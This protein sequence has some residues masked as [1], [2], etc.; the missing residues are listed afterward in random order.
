[1]LYDIRL[2]ISYSYQN[3][4]AANR[5]M[6]R[7]QPR[8]GTTQRL[9]SGMVSIDP[10]PDFRLDGQDFFGNRRTEIAYDGHL[11][12]YSFRFAGRVERVFSPDAFDLSCPLRDLAQEVAGVHSISPDAPHHF[13]GPSP[14]IGSVG[15]IVSFAH[16]QLS[17]ADPELSTWEAVSR[18]SH[19]LHGEI[20]FDPG[21]TDVTTPPDIA[22]QARRGVC[23]D[24]S[25]I[26]IAALRGLG[27][28]AGYVSGFLRTE[29]PEGEA[30]LEGTDAMHAWVRAWCG[31]K[32]GWVDID[33]TNDMRVGADHITVAIGR[34]YADVAPVIG[35]LRT[36]GMH[37]TSHSVDVVPI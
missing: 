2:T 27:I 26:M 31:T 34:D 3:P 29:P 4:A 21:A 37:A 18:I 7:M 24:I 23:Q 20:E 35:S 14:R 9:I 13:L 30:R 25:H 8:T 17:A 33:P 28:P 15:D 11:S 22:F 6:L 5:T 32:V 12:S 16:A 10:T 19:A 36:A 1:M